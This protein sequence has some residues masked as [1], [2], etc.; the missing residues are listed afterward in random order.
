M[1]HGLFTAK[2]TTSTKNL[3]LNAFLMRDFYFKRR[4]GKLL[5]LLSDHLTPMQSKVR[6]SA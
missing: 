4:V 1:G 2:E 3:I 6:K 5:S